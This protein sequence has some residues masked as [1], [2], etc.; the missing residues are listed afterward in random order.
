MKHLRFMVTALVCAMLLLA[1]GVILA[2]ESPVGLTPHYAHPLTGVVEDPGNNSAIGQ[3]MTQ[4]VLDGQGT[5]EENGDGSWVTIH[6]HMA[7][8]LG[9]VG[10]AVQNR[11]DSAFYQVSAQEVGRSGDTISYRFQVPASDAVIRLEVEVKDMGRAVIFYG[12]MDGNVNL[13]AGSNSS[14]GSNN[15]T[16]QSTVAGSSTQ[17]SGNSATTTGSNNNGGKKRDAS[18]LGKAVETK[19]AKSSE[20]EGD[21][22]GEN[23][24]LLTKDS[25][26]LAE[27]TGGGASVNQGPWGTF[28]RGVVIALI[29]VLSLLAFCSVFGAIALWALTKK[30]RYFNDLREASLY[31][32]EERL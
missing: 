27:L 2:A 30:L 13:P 16:Q 1:P 28:T 31:D 11:G 23:H 7:E 14:G 19:E 10:F 26:E 18:S 15:T 4:S 32:A 29:V 5:Y 25:P 17:S 12:L 22:F 3:G 6:L 9:N 20:L 21:N 8:R 24:G